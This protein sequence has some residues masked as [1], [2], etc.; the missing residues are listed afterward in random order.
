MN[1]DTVGSNYRTAFRPA[2][3]SRLNKFLDGLVLTDTDI[4]VMMDLCVG[5]LALSVFIQNS[6]LSFQPYQTEIAG[7]SPFCAV[8]TGLC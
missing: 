4:G 8:F 7:S 2:I 5:T 3:T 1:N 6:Y